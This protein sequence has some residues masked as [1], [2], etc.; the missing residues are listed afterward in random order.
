VWREGAMA[1]LSIAVDVQPA[2]AKA[3]ATTARR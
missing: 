3:L 2:P 1:D